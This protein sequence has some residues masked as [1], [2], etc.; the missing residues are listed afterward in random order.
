MLMALVATLTGWSRLGRK[1]G[2]GCTSRRN[3]GSDKLFLE[4]SDLKMDV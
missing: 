1:S 3:G 2:S 4:V